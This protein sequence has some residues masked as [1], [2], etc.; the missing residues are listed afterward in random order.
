MI[1]Q[2]CKIQVYSLIEGARSYFTHRVIH[3][4]SDPKVRSL[5]TQLKDAMRPGYSKLLLNETLLPEVQCP[6]FDA[7]GDINMMCI[8]ASIKRTESQLTRLIESIETLRVDKVWRSADTDHKDCLI[9]VI[10]ALD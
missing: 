1:Y 3:N 6:A 10:R 5:L 4:W 2:V 7:A 8:L 9:E